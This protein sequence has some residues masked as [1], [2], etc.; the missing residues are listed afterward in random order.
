[1]RPS[2]Q[3]TFARLPAAIGSARGSAFPTTT[4]PVATVRPWGRIADARQE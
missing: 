4:D 1:M 3:S 2:L